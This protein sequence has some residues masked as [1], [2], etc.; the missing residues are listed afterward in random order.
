MGSG[1]CVLLSYLYLGC[2]C[3]AFTVWV[4]HVYIYS[5]PE[6]NCA[7]ENHGHFDFSIHAFVAPV[8]GHSVSSELELQ[9]VTRI[10]EQICLDMVVLETSV[11]I[12]CDWTF[13]SH[14][15]KRLGNGV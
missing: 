8:D 12:V 11:C 2:V 14:Q 7:K 4:R 9:S 1:S 10:S 6:Q 3:V 15:W 5:S 13:R